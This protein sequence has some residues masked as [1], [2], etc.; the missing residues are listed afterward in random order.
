MVDVTFALGRHPHTSLRLV[1]NRVE[2]KVWHHWHP[3]YWGILTNQY[4]TI[5]NICSSLSGTTAVMMPI[6]SINSIPAERSAQPEPE[7]ISG[8]REK[9][10]C[11]WVSTLFQKFT[12]IF[13][14]SASMRQN[15]PQ[16]LLFT[17]GSCLW[18]SAH[19][20]HEPRWPHAEVKPVTQ[21]NS[22]LPTEVVHICTTEWEES[23]ADSSTWGTSA[24]PESEGFD[25]CSFL[26]A[27]A[28]STQTFN[29]SKLKS[30]DVKVEKWKIFVWEVAFGRLS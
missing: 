6:T 2:R 10:Q 26:Q 20:W 28:S 30:V 5:T 11:T 4:K 25:V 17:V 21:S 23:S 27:S 7:H 16:L 14:R 19:Y 22:P 12:W 29:T 15:Y 8:L 3:L 9:R 24:L 13:Q 1:L 18:V